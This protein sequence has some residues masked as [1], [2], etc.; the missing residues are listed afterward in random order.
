MPPNSTNHHKISRQ[1]TLLLL[2]LLINITYSSWGASVHN[3][4][5]IEPY[6]L[7]DASKLMTA[8]IGSDNKGINVL[9]V[10]TIINKK[11]LDKTSLI[12]DE[13]KGNYNEI[14]LKFS[15][16]DDKALSFKV[17]K[18]GSKQDSI[19]LSN[20][21]IITDWNVHWQANVIQTDEVW[22]V[23]ITIPWQSALSIS[24]SISIYISQYNEHEKQLIASPPIKK[25]SVNFLSKLTAV[26]IN[27]QIPIYYSHLSPFINVESNFKNDTHTINNGF[28]VF[29]GVT[30]I[31]DFAF[32]YKPDFAQVEAKE[33]VLNYSS[34]ETFFSENRPFFM[35]TDD[36]IND[37][38]PENLILFHTPRIGESSDIEYAANY[39]AKFDLFD[40]SLFHAKENN[41][42]GKEYLF[43][44]ATL[45]QE[46]NLLTLSQI[47]SKNLDSR[48]NSKSSSAHF[49]LSN[50]ENISVNGV[51]FYNKVNKIESNSSFNGWLST[52]YDTNEYNQHEINLFNYSDKLDINDFGFVDRKNRKQFEYEYNHEW[53]NAPN[54]QYL[55]DVQS[56]ASIEYGTLQTGEILP[57]QYAIKIEGKLFKT[58]NFEIEHEIL[59]SGVDDETADNDF[60]IKT[61]PT[62]ATDIFAKFI[63]TSSVNTNIEIERSENLWGNVSL[64]YSIH[65]D[66]Q[67][68]K[69]TNI[70]ATYSRQNEDNWLDYDQDNEFNRYNLAQQ[71]IQLR[72]DYSYKHRHEF[73]FIVFSEEIDAKSIDK[74]LYK[75]NTASFN[76]VS[77]GEDLYASEVSLQARYHYIANSIYDVYLVYSRG[78]EAE[79]AASNGHSI[80]SN[81]TESPNIESIFLKLT[82]NL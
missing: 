42:N 77:L 31:H 45:N 81:I 33:V 9:I 78:I 24:D 82:M 58:H 76:S 19:L 71:S 44:N 48:N 15:K 20:G 66:Y 18:N 70:S 65:A 49:N 57:T 17:G 11:T 7:K 1:V 26:P 36:Y 38:G 47:Q 54:A 29:L 67:V 37:S 53:E 68:W 69:N 25:T 61:N 6:T 2:I 63:V 5:V 40:I 12:D 74:V 59:T 80:I 8:S 28:D 32:T 23:N 34:I 41:T 55:T 64:E 56:S 46:N 4:K 35:S 51:I 21:D 73:R 22:R 52:Q 72:L 27:K 79:T 10:N 39:N 14:I 50:S 75:E 13:I 16:E 62:Y 30:G 3:F 60:L 43:L